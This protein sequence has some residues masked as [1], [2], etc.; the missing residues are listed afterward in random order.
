MNIA[1]FADVHSNLE[2]LQAFIET[3]AKQDVQKYIF[4][5]DIIGY[6]PNPNECIEAVRKLP[7]VKMVLGNHDAAAIWKS[8][9]YNM[10]GHAREALFW[11]MKKLLADNVQI[12]KSL[13]NK[14]VET[15]VYYCH[16][17]PQNPESW[18][19][20]NSQSQAFWVF[21]K[22]DYRV[23]FISHTHRPRL[24]SQEKYWKIKEERIEEDASFRLHPDRRYIINCG[25]VGQP[26]DGNVN[27][28]YCIYNERDQSVVFH[29]FDYDREKTIAKINKAKLPD[30]L[31][32]RLKK[33]M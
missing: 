32:R 6:G 33:G 21:R 26:R 7:N 4:L 17:T 5:G 20:V 30:F 19:Y 29:R 22:T 12:L 28:S 27:G 2:A 23:S 3:T 8:S 15:D 25:S 31:A 10:S 11:T 14:L 18:T 13:R 1:I 9:P 16:T 24:L